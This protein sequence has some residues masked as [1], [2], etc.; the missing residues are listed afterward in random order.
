MCADDDGRDE[1]VGVRASRTRN[2]VRTGWQF[3][4]LWLLVSVCVFVC[5]KDAS[6]HVTIPQYTICTYNMPPMLESSQRT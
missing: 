6:A 1:T 5:A 3:A 2:T 4:A